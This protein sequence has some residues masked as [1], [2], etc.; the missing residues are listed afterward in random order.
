MSKWIKFVSCPKRKRITN[1]WEVQSLMGAG[2][3]SISWY[4]A[5]RTYAFFPYDDTIY[6]DDCLLDIANFIKEQ[7]EKRK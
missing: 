5:W 6:E 2:I 7:M 3:G 4:S 1:I